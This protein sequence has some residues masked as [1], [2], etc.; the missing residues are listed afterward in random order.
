MGL[1]AH[2]ENPAAAFDPVCRTNVDEAL[3]GMASAPRN[4][5]LA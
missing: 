3:M 1:A 5:L 4:P 2:G